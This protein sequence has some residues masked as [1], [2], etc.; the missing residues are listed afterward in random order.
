MCEVEEWRANDP[1]LSVN[2]ADRETVVIGSLGSS[3]GD[4]VRCASAGVGTPVPALVR[5]FEAHPEG[6][7]NS[8]ELQR[9]TGEGRLTETS[10]RER[11]R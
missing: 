2:R 8:A 5:G 6:S 10:A 9:R 4:L 3:G 1:V 11:R 7:R